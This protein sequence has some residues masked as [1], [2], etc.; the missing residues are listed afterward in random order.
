[1]LR[2]DDIHARALEIWRGRETDFPPRVRRMD[3]DDMDKTS[4]A[5]GR[6]FEQAA[7]ELGWK[8]GD[9][10]DDTQRAAMIEQAERE[11]G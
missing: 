2:Y 3:P 10:V 7:R 9:A 5:W 11:V 8:P 4:G 1:M 6:V